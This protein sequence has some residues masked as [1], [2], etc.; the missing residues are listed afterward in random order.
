MRDGESG[1]GGLLLSQGVSRYCFVLLVTLTN[2]ILVERGPGNVTSNFSYM[3]EAL[4]IILLC[5]FSLNLRRRNKSQI[6]EVELPTMSFTVRGARNA[7]RHLHETFIT[8]LGEHDEQ[9][10]TD[11]S[12]DTPEEDVQ[13]ETINI[14]L[15]AKSDSQ[16]SPIEA[17]KETA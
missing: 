10:D 2:A 1:I 12:H 7:L 13:I 9:D 15:R 4:S 3:Q 14:E 16:S 5:Q 8:E 17:S 6:D 11:D